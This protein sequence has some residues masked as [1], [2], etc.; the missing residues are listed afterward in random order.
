MVNSP[1]FELWVLLIVALCVGGL[2]YN[3][4][5]SG[6]PDG[7][8]GPA[9]VRVV[10]P[11][12]G[13]KAPVFTVVYSHPL[14]YSNLRAVKVLFNSSL[15]GRSACYVQYDSSESVFRL[16]QDSGYESSAI[17]VGESADIENNQC[18]LHGKESSVAGAETELTL[19]LALSFK[20]SFDGPK[21]IYMLAE[22]QSGTPTSFE[23]RGEWVV[24]SSYPR[25]TAR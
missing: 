1:K 2:V 16:V 8:Q 6:N 11:S 19:K 7:L 25:G 17:R 21:N 22:D 9:N 12:G 13:S 24:E 14:G 15:D 5:A 18:I 10:A 4:L 3:H 23:Q 20:T